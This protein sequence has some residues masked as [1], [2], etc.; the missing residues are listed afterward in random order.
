M[1]IISQILYI[2]QFDI[3]SRTKYFKRVINSID[4]IEKVDSQFQL[5]YCQ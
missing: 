1:V 4:S 5:K 3:I 2:Y